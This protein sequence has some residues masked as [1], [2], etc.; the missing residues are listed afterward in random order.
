MGKAGLRT[1]DTSSQIAIGLQLSLCRE[2][3]S[4]FRQL[5]QAVCDRYGNEGEMLIRDLFIA[6]MNCP[7]GEAA[8]SQE[9]ST[10]RINVALVKLLAGSSISDK[11]GKIEH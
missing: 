11:S 7:C 5:C 3:A 4:A 8:P 1:I 9:N 10:R 6:D 2:L